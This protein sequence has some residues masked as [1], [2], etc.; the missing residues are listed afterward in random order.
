MKKT[1]IIF[2]VA[3]LLFSALSLVQCEHVIYLIIK[4]IV[5][6]ICFIAVTVT[7]CLLANSLDHIVKN[8]K[9]EEYGDE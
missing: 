3:G 6:A 5:E 9:N 4:G 7:G 1:I 2:I 8:S